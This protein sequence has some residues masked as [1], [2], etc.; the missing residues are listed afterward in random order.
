MVYKYKALK[1]LLPGQKPIKAWRII[2]SYKNFCNPKKGDVL[3]FEGFSSFANTFDGVVEFSQYIYSVREDYCIFEMEF[4]IGTDIVQLED[5]GELFTYPNI[6]VEV[7]GDVKKKTLKI[8]KGKYSRRYNASIIPVKLID[9]GT[10]NI[11]DIPGVIEW[12]NR[13]KERRQDMESE[14]QYIMDILEQLLLEDSRK[15][16]LMKAIEEENIVDIEQIIKDCDTDL[17]EVDENGE[18]ALFYAARTGNQRIIYL[19]TEEG[20]DLYI[21]NNQEKTAVDIYPQLS[22]DIHNFSRKRIPECYGEVKN[23]TY[24]G[25]K[26]INKAIRHQDYNELFED[27]YSFHA[28][29]DMF[30]ALDNSPLRN[31]GL[32]IYRGISS[33][34]GF[35]CKKIKE[36]DEITLGGISSFTTNFIVAEELS[37]HDS[38]NDNR[39]I[40]DIEINKAKV[41]YMIYST[42][43]PE[44][45]EVITYPNIRIKITK[46]DGFVIEAI[47]IDEGVKNIL[48]L[49]GFREAL[50][51]NNV[52]LSTLIE[53]SNVVNYLRAFYT[54]STQYEFSQDQYTYLVD[55]LVDD[56]T[57]LKKYKSYLMD[58]VH[59]E[60]KLD[61]DR[62]FIFKSIF[63]TDFIEKFSTTS[64]SLEMIHSKEFWEIRQDSV[65]LSIFK[66][67]LKEQNLETGFS[68]V[69]E[70]RGFLS[71]FSGY[72]GQRSVKCILI[73]NEMKLYESHTEKEDLHRGDMIFF[74]SPF[75]KT[76]DILGTFGNVLYTIL[77][78]HP[79]GKPSVVE[80]SAYPNE[81]DYYTDRIS[82]F[83]QGIPPLS[84]NVDSSGHKKVSPSPEYMPPE[85]TEEGWRLLGKDV[86]TGQIMTLGGKFRTFLEIK[87]CRD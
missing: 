82:S 23:Y 19:L 65:V 13:N 27:S 41:L 46:I 37:Y 70:D 8:G 14:I 48:D 28:L 25:D 7:T 86:K 54:L 76:L 30:K 20:A 71:N 29:L 21:K 5:L 63:S 43:Y 16:P 73:L 52:N 67:V 12:Y 62:Y 49:P 33:Y 45:D 39:C 3:S 84:L 56:N 58:V 11:G 59:F 74:K 51:K 34:P 80:L 69:F 17:N 4:P 38:D 72:F 77:S 44:E 26:I 50:V 24:H 2:K 61:R 42:F 35:D 83:E 85:L 53:K 60:E 31:T 6:K 1:D 22:T 40:I 87:K 64:R 57:F 75:E 9:K 36:G 81:E 32:H 68:P 10:T 47:I 79:V 18:T 55:S 66:K 78:Y 15:T